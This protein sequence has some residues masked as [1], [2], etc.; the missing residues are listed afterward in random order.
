M[1]EDEGAVQHDHDAT[2]DSWHNVTCSEGFVHRT[3]CVDY[4]NILEFT[5]RSTDDNSG[6]QK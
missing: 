2:I 3:D 4:L 1:I 5:F 6:A